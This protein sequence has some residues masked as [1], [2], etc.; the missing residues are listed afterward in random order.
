M[1]LYFQLC[2]LSLFCLWVH[3]GGRGSNVNCKGLALLST[4]VSC[5]TVI[6][7]PRKD[8]DF[9]DFQTRIMTH[10]NF[11]LLIVTLLETLTWVRYNILNN[12]TLEFLNMMYCYVNKISV[13]YSKMEFV[14]HFATSRRQCCWRHIAEFL[15]YILLQKIFLFSDFH[16]WSRHFHVK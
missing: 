9:Q 11:G 12:E 1:Q 10:K 8:I 5:G 13:L 6:S 16:Q 3:G 4:I 14:P 2:R 15:H 7:Q